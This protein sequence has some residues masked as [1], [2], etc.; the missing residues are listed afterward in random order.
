MN[1]KL[2]K[3][4]KKYIRGEKARIRREFLNSKEREEKIKNLLEKFKK[5]ISKK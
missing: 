3:S 2:P 1:K 5:D 4:L